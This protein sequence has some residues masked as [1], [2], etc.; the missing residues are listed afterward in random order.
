MATFQLTEDE[1][2]SA[3][4]AIVRRRLTRASIAYLV[5][6][7]LVAA[8]LFFTR[9]L[10]NIG[11]LIFLL[12]IPVSAYLRIRRLFA[13]GFRTQKSL[14]DPITLN[15]GEEGI[16]YSQEMGS[17]LLLW[18]RVYKWHENKQF[19]FLYESD[20]AARIIPK[21]ALSPEEE[22]ILREHLI[23]TRRA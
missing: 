5:A 2:L 3:S 7:A 16:A 21:R 11:L 1:Y 19:F 4:F 20:L 15:L 6:F 23:G 12:V 17:Y 13:K 18:E 8:S 10:V 22:Q 14:Q 9:E